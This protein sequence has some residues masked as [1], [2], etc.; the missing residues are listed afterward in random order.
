ME[1]AG[2]VRKLTESRLQPHQFLVDVVVSAKKSPARIIVFIDGDEGVSI[3]DCADISRSLAEELDKNGALENYTLEVSTPGVD[4]PLKL[5]RQYL[6]NVGRRLKVQTAGGQIEGKLIAADGEKLTLET[7]QG[8]G[9]K[10]VVTP[11]EVPML[12]VVKA[13]VMV[14]F[15]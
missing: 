13:L 8:T 9:K 3:D 10:K 11:V 14:S 2:E 7:E 15:K 12:S 4:Q 5:K 1:L 6:K